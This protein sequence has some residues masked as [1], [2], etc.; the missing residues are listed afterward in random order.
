MSI[1]PF[2]QFV[3][4]PKKFPEL[5]E[6]AKRSGTIRDFHG[7]HNL[8]YESPLGFIDIIQTRDHISRAFFNKRS[9]F[10]KLPFTPSS[11]LLTRVKAWFD[12][13]FD[14]EPVNVCEIPIQIDW[15]THFQHDVWNTVRQIP[16]GEVRSYKWIAEQI[17]RPKAVRAV[18]NAVGA[19]PIT[20]LLPCHRVIG[21]NGKLGGYGGGLKRKCQLLTLEGYP[22]ETLK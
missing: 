20:I 6:K 12:G 14:K 11:P 1:N 16:Y 17:G 10:Y 21:S 3:K 22:V 9:P 4:S 19:N 15:G 2:E 18:G 13:Y 7:L 8:R 5:S